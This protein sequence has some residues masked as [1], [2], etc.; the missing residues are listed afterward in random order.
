MHAFLS[1]F[2]LDCLMFHC[3]TARLS[4]PC[5]SAPHK[6][7]GA[8]REMRHTLTLWFQG[9]EGP[10]SATGL[11]GGVG[12]ITKF[13]LSPACCDVTDIVLAH[14]ADAAEGLARM[15][16]LVGWGAGRGG[17]EGSE[18]VYPHICCQSKLQP[19][20][21]DYL[22]ACTPDSY[23]GWLCFALCCAGA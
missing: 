1:S 15:V 12:D 16:S 2:S 10:L 7:T 18:R 5:L 4:T 22:V 20:S 9:G 14:E 21:A 17:R 23:S 8:V 6:P 11:Q 13:K 19:F 3:P